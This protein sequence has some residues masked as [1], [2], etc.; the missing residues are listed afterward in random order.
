[1]KM[2]IDKD[3]LFELLNDCMARYRFAP[4]PISK[5]R[6]DEIRAIRDTIEEQLP[7]LKVKPK[8]KGYSAHKVACIIA[9][10]FGDDCACNF[11]NISDWLPEY[12]DF[13]DTCCPNP[14][15]VACWEQYLKHKAKHE[16]DPSHP[17]ADDVMM[18]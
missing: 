12:C 15:G 2:L 13:T 7:T 5:I 10:L 18:G 17:F 1:M 8:V 4:S 6:V 14:A 16:D 11:N 3:K 9:E